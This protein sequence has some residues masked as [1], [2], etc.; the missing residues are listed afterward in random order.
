MSK[1]IFVDLEPFVDKISLLLDKFSVNYD[2]LT[3]SEFSLEKKCDFPRMIFFNANKGKEY[4]QKQLDQTFLGDL[5][6]LTFN[7][8][9][10]AQE[11]KEELNKLLLSSDKFKGVIDSTHGIG[12]IFAE[13][14]GIRKMSDLIFESQANDEYLQGFE[15]K[16]E[17]MK[18]SISFQFERLKKLHKLIVPKKEINFGSMRTTCRYIAG[19]DGMSEFWDIGRTEKK[20]LTLILS[21]NGSGELGRVLGTVIDFLG[22]QKYGEEAMLLFY[23]ILEKKLEEDFSLFMMCANSRN[24]QCS[25][26]ARGGGP[27]LLNGKLIDVEKNGEIFKIQL[28]QGD[29][30]FIVSSGL[31]DNC[32]KNFS[33]QNLFR[34]LTNKWSE[35]SYEL[36]HQLFLSAKT[37]EKGRLNYSDGTCIIV[38]VVK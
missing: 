28:S 27:V 3:S 16:V 30:L 24:N 13:I 20:Q 1:W 5:I 14:N 11:E 34:F 33:K 15:S 31:L 22:S 4:I 29:K 21:T 35:P 12:F 9:N 36:I 10:L 7:S 18:K 17:E 2:S 38:E 25:I 19:S 8:L 26:I 6:Y 32:K 23:Q 37:N